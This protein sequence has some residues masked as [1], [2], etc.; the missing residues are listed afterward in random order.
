[1]TC[2]ANGD[3]C[4]T[5]ATCGPAGSGC[6]CATRAGGGA[7]FCFRGAACQACTSDADCAFLGV[8]YA[9]LQAGCCPGGTACAVTC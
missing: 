3:A 9:C 6:H 2:Q 8:G 5:T 7:D 1:V 4:T